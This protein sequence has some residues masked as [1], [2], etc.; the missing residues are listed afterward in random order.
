MVGAA[1]IGGG[2]ERAKIHRF[3]DA[4]RHDQ[5]D[6]TDNAPRHDV[7]QLSRHIGSL[8][9]NL[10]SGGLE[11]GR[12]NSRQGL[13]NRGSAPPPTGREPRAKGPLGTSSA[14]EAD[15]TPA[16]PSVAVDRF[17]GL[18]YTI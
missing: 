2:R 3:T 6:S 10:Q 5:D 9:C 8:R 12:N 14:T 11:D 18:A 16:F 13:A 17:Y 1:P 7:S 15:L 4:R